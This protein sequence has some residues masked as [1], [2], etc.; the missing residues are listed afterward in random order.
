MA[1]PAKYTTAEERQA[2]NAARQAAFRERTVRVDRAVL[3]ALVGA[4]EAAAAAG[5]PVARR[6]RTGTADGLLRNLAVY[7]EAQARRG[8]TV[9]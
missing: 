2:A 7:F 5:D 4:V 8:E 6:V 1:R 3:A 9:R